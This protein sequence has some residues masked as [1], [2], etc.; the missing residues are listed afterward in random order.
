MNTPASTVTRGL[1]V[2][3][4]L[5]VVACGFIPVC[6]AADATG[7]RQTAVRFADLDVSSAQG[8]ATLYR[9]IHSAAEAVCSAVSHDDLSSKM[10]R[11]ACVHLAIEDAVTRVDRPAL[12]AVYATNYPTLRAPNI[13]VADRRA[14]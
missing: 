7:T 8:A 12:S 9:R 14:R 4:V 3:A 5:S 11:E 13:V 6:S 2:G 1:M 10:N